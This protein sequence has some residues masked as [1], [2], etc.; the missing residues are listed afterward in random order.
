[1]RAS[2][3]KASPPASPGGNRARMR[4]L[5][6]V[7]GRIKGWRPAREVLREVRAVP[8]RFLQYDVATGVGGHPLDRIA[9]IHG[10]SNEGKSEFALG[11]GASFVERG[12][13]FGL[14]DAERTTPPAWVRTLAGSLMEQPNFMALPASTYEKAV[15]GVRGFAT[16]IADARAAGDLP[17]DCTGLVVVDSIRKLVP[18]DIMKRILADGIEGGGKKGRRGKPAGVDGMGGRAAQIKAALNAAWMDELVPLM[19]DT[20]CAI[21]IVARETDDD[22]YEGVKVGGGKALVYES[23]LRLRIVRQQ[24]WVGP[25]GKKKY[26]GEKHTVGIHKTK[27]AGRIEPVV[28][29]SYFTSNGVHVPAGFW[30]E[31][32]AL[33]VG[34]ELGVVD[35]KGSWY[36]FDGKR[37]GNGE[38]AAVQR[39]LDEPALLAAV[40]SAV[41]EAA[42]PA[43]SPST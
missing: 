7:A 43:A 27:V 40:Q 42:R 26:V 12:H 31:R 2:K 15:D 21:L 39:L 4:Q 8:T 1:M 34:Q 10:P 6:A 18:A 38:E 3:A 32:D 23:S 22:S 30:P 17:D 20:G 35:L 28:Y 16:T 13:F 33:E 14:L 11:L 29:A 25:E 5:E 24:L 36:G 41:R 9:L 19:A 37:L